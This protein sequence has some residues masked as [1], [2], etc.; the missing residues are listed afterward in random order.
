MSLDVT[1]NKLSSLGVHGHGSRAEHH[2]IGNDGLGIDAWERFG[3]LVGK[4]SDLVGHRGRRCAEMSM[5][6]ETAM[7]RRAERRQTGEAGGEERRGGA[8]SKDAEV[9]RGGAGRR[10]ALR[11]AGSSVVGDARTEPLPVSRLRRRF[12]R[13][14]GPLSGDLRSRPT[15]VAAAASPHHLPEHFHPT[16]SSPHPRGPHADPHAVAAEAWAL[17]YLRRRRMARR[18]A[19]VADATKWPRRPTA[20]P[21]LG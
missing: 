15:D 17:P 20:S 1:I 14:R 5:R 8:S 4:S 13:G 12:A 11:R 7:M 3:S 18:D 2:A 19:I 9:P 16:R 6:M 21:S 10:R